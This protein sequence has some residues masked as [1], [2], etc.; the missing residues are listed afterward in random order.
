MVV[1]GRC[2]RTRM[3]I[4]VVIMMYMGTRVPSELNAVNFV[5]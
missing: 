3:C 5:L 1:N 2:E 4:M